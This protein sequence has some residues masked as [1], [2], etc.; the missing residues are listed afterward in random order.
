MDSTDTRTLFELI[1]KLELF[2]PELEGRVTAHLAKT[3]GLMH[4]ETDA[5]GRETVAS[6]RLARLVAIEI[7]DFLC[8][9]FDLPDKGYI[10]A[11]RPREH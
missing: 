8:W 7:L 5:Q 9:A 4:F 10:P 1:Q 6:Y 3:P 2:T 11:E